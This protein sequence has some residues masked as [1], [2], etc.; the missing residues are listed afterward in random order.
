M[1]RY[2][3]LGAHKGGEMKRIR[4][5]LEAEPLATE[6]EIHAFEAHP[7]LARRISR[8][9]RRDPSVRVEPCALGSE[10]GTCSL[11]LNRNLVGSSIYKSKNNVIPGKQVD[12]PCIRFSRYLDEQL[13]ENWQSDFN[14][15]KANIEGAEWDVWHDLLDHDMVKAFDLWLGAKEGHG[16]W[17]EDICKIEEMQGKAEALAASFEEAGVSVYRFSAWDKNIPNSDVPAVLHRLLANAS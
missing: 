7:R 13:P 4:E 11:F 10:E 9:F 1:I 8:Q 16:G 17:A 15:I 14:I 5:M 12:V 6:W 2:F 3:D